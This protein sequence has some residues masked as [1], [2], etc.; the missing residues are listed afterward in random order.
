MRI[1]TWNVAGRVGAQPEQAAALA[2]V[3]ADIV[4]LQEVTARTAPLWRACLAA[5][6]LPACEAAIDRLPPKPTR[7][8]LAVLTAARTTVS[9]LEGPEVP[10]PERALAC[11]V[12][13]AEVVN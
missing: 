11:S 1:V 4:A 6:G 3:G 12:G 7:R 8:R 2:G 9:R 5:A 13:G 10:W